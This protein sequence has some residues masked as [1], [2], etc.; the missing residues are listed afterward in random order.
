ML[1]ISKLINSVIQ[2]VIFFVNLT[3]DYS[4]TLNVDNYVAS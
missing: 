3:F 4:N 2:V 1:H